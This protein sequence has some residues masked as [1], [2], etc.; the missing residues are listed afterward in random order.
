MFPVEPMDGA[1]LYYSSADGRRTLRMPL[2]G[3]APETV[4]EKGPQSHWALAASGICVLESKTQTGPVI[5]FFHFATGRRT[6]VARLP[7]EPGAYYRST[8]RALS[9]TADARW[10]AWDQLDRYESDIRLVENFR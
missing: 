6:R 8:Y 4:L 2:P 5:E 10:I 1:T 3:G 7:K 9:I